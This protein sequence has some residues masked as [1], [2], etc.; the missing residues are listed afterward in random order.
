MLLDMNTDDAASM[1]WPSLGVTDGHKPDNAAESPASSTGAQS[2]ARTKHVPIVRHK[3]G[4]ERPERAR[5]SH[6]CE[7]CR[8]R[9]TKCDGERPA[10]RRCTH[11]GTNCHY[12]Y[13]KGWKKRKYDSSKLLLAISFADIT[14]E[15]LP[16]ICQRPLESL[17]GVKTCSVRFIPWYHRRCG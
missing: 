1:S 7:P 15:G 12:G 6:A 8:E 13:G 9:K 11:T 3:T 5:T 4:Y 2:I 17:Q 10:C 14:T 16:K